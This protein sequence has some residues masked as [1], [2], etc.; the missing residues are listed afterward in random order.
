MLRRKS[1]VAKKRKGASGTAN[2]AKKLIIANWKMNPDNFHDAKKIFDDLKRKKLRTKKS[3][4]VICPP[5]LFLGE[6]VRNYRGNQFLFGAQDVS[7]TQGTESTGEISAEMLKNLGVKYVIIGHAE[8]R[9]LGETDETVSMKIKRVMDLGLT[10]IVC[11]GEPERDADGEYLRFLEEEIRGSLSGIQKN[12]VN[13]I[14]IAY[15]PVWTIG[16]GSAAMSGNDLHQMTIF[17]KKILNQIYDKKVAMQIPILYGG[18][19]DDENVSEIING[20]QVDGLLIGRAS[21]N[22]HVFA[23][24]LKAIG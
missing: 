4:A 3:V 16:K 9:E 8:R 22:P 18:S 11:I 19:V 23:D 13:K 2:A 7:Y 14:V 20:G 10:P 6:L 1:K 12:K 17:I 15:E 24:I 5:P 21:L